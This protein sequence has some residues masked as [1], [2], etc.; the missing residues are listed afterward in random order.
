MTPS[1]SQR[2]WDD[3]RT[4]S[5]SGADLVVSMPKNELAVEVPPKNG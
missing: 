1:Q 5:V 3:Q 2:F 4:A